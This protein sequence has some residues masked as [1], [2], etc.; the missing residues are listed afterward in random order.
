MNKIEDYIEAKLTAKNV[1]RRVICVL[2]EDNDFDAFEDTMKFSINTSYGYYGSSTL[3]VRF[4]P[5]TN[6]TGHSAISNKLGKYLARAISQ[7]SRELFLLAAK[8]AEEDAEKARLHAVEEADQVLL[9]Q[10]R[11]ENV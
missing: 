7:R 5:A 9:D 8:Y 6:T 4:Y 10:E 3:S 1:K 11:I 2:G